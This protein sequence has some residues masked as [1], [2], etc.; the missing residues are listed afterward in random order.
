[1]PTK[2]ATATRRFRDLLGDL[3]VLVEDAWADG[4]L[5]WSC[6]D[7]TRV[8]DH[9]APDRFDVSPTEA[10]RQAEVMREIRQEHRMARK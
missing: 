1:M 4:T 7:Y 8:M 6:A 9:I 2:P 3:I 10:R 5:R